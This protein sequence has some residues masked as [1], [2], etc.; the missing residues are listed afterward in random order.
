MDAGAVAAMR[1]T[2]IGEGESCGELTQRLAELT[3]GAIAETL[4]EIAAGSVTWTEQE[5]ALATLAPK[6][7]PEDAHLDFRESAEALARR[8]RAMAPKPG[9]R[10]Q[11]RVGARSELLRILAA[12]PLEGKADASPGALRS[13]G[14]PP[15]CAATGDGWLAL[16]VLQRAGGRPVAAA[17]FLRGRPLPDAARL[18]GM[19]ARIADGPADG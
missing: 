3:A 8:V 10:A 17:D 9:A 7:T 13:G 12:H 18:D 15:L 4:D 1:R 11:L 5:H 16:D 6:L 19:A 14:D 2:P